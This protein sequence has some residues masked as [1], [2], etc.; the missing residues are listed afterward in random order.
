FGLVAAMTLLAGGVALVTYQR[1]GGTLTEI[2][3]DRIPGLNAAMSTARASAEIAAAAPD[4]LSLRST[5]ETAAA[6]SG[7]AEKRKELSRLID[8]LSSLGVGE[9]ADRLREYLGQCGSILE[10]LAGAVDR[11]LSAGAEREAMLTAIVA[12]HRGVAEALDPLID[13]L[14]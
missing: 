6:M 5:A 11:R 13:D 12:A 9:S 3:D 2:R 1:V 10:P 7:L 14:S 8:R 4:L